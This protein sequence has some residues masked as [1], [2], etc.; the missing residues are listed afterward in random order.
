MPS[1]P[2]QVARCG[3]AAVAAARV[4]RVSDEIRARR[5]WARA[6]NDGAVAAACVSRDRDEMAASLGGAP[7]GCAGLGR[8]VVEFGRMASTPGSWHTA[9]RPPARRAGI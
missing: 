6:A 8:L 9:P 1:P 3:G 2:R 7:R 4:L 5:G